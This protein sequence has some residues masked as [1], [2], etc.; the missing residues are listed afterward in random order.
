M[1]VSFFVTC[2]VDQ[3]WSSIGVISVEVNNV[4]LLWS[5]Y[6]DGQC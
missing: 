3:M 5:M 6:S 4:Q 2:L 1:R